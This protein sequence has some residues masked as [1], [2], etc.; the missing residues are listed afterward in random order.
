MA[1]LNN[2]QKLMTV[3]KLVQDFDAVEGKPLNHCACSQ[4]LSKEIQKVILGNNYKE[5]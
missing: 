4:D 5:K 2:I 3:L 1:E